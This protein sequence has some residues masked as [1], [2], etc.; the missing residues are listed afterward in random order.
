[1]AY[2]YNYLWK[3]ILKGK[4]DKVGVII[5]L[6][7]RPPSQ[8]FDHNARLLYM[9]GLDKNIQFHQDDGLCLLEHDHEQG[10]RSNAIAVKEAGHWLYQQH[11]EV[12]FAQVDAFIQELK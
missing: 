6:G 8:G 10:W 2:P 5:D 9:Y 12:C 1:M 11:A 7:R 4:L 3:V